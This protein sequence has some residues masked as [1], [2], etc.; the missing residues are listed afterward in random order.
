MIAKTGP[1]RSCP[2]KRLCCHH[3]LVPLFSNDGW[4]RIGIDQIAEAEHQ[5]RPSLVKRGDDCPKDR[6]GIEATR[7]NVTED[8][9]AN[10]T[11]RHRR[12]HGSLFRCIWTIPCS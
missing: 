1:E 6:R 9:D 3:E 5:T 11:W 10:T 7:A 8:R 2:D 12:R 4:L